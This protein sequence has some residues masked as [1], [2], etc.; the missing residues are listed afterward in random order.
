LWTTEEE[1]KREREE[2]EEARER[3]EEK[4]EEEREEKKEK[5]E[6]RRKRRKK[7]EERE[8]REGKDLQ[9][10]Q[11]FCEKYHQWLLRMVREYGGVVFRGF[12]IE[13][14]YDFD[15]LLPF[16]DPFIQDE[17]YLGTSPRN[18]LNDTKYVSTASEFPPA[19]VIPEHLE[20]SFKPF[21]PKQIFFFADQ[22]N[23][24]PGGQTPLS[25]FRNVWEDLSPDVQNRFKKNGI[26]YIRCYYS[27]NRFNIDPLRTKSWQDMFSTD[28]KEEA[29]EKAKEEGFSSFW[30]SDDLCLTN[31]AESPTRIHEIT[32]EEYW[33][34]HLHVLHGSTFTI[35]IGWAAQI[36]QA[37]TTLFRYYMFN[38][39]FFFRSLIGFS[40]GHDVV[41]ENGEPLPFEDVL[42]VRKAIA[43]NSWI[44]PHQ[45]GDVIWLDN[46]RIAH[47]RQPWFS[48]GRKIYVAWD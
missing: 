25:D 8:R 23:S 32:G 42:V 40:F 15:D 47:G 43:Q 45:K 1:E 18:R 27:R 16:I 4:R 37:W 28:D 31:V 21:P 11:F 17:L 38:T 44:Y 9:K 30:E 14:V 34:N 22:P 2:K 41:A 20:M 6:E 24:P 29:V 13:N 36:Q 35:P 7:K 39:Y 12:E 26:K 46:Q 10:L 3:E 48:G 5:K 33:G 19:M